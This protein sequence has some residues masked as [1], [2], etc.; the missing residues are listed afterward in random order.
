[1]LSRP[2]FHDSPPLTTS[3]L[4]Y[5]V[6]HVEDSLLG[7]ILAA[8]ARL[9]KITRGRHEVISELAA[10]CPIRAVLAEPHKPLL[11][12]GQRKTSFPNGI[13]VIVEDGCEFCLP[14]GVYHQLERLS[15]KTRAETLRATP[16]P[17]NRPFVGLKIAT[18]PKQLRKRSTLAIVLGGIFC[19]ALKMRD[20]PEMADV[21]CYEFAKDAV[22][23]MPHREAV[24]YLRAFS[25]WLTE[26]RMASKSG[27]K[28]RSFSAIL[29]DGRRFTD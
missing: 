1:M 4:A 25:R 20:L 17:D 29:S 13:D 23:N 28:A 12:R 24:T 7:E 8:V 9:H 18:P 5:A 22:R 26:V 15:R 14:R 10:L 3:H 6:S 2:A 16:A 19:A 11:A 27:P 21:D